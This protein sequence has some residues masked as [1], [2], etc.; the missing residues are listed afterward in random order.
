MILHRDLDIGEL[1]LCP[2]LPDRKKQIKYFLAS[3]LDE[4]EVSFLLAKGW[5]KFGIYFFQPSCPDCRECIPLRVLTS[6]FK[7]S[8]SQRRNLKKNTDIEVAFAPLEFSERAFE[9]YKTH[10]HQRFSQECNLEEF[11]MNFY[12]PSTPCLQSE[13]YLNGELIGLGFLDR[14]KDCLS[15]VYFIYD[16]KYSHLGLGTYSVLEE[17]K[18]TRSLGL[19]YYCLGYYVQACQKMAYKNNFKPSEHYDWLQDKWKVT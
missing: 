18:H 19:Q 2:Y 11:I 15:S 1:S 14:G 6:K 17:I 4:S 9:I 7:P 13:F 10:S 8:K 3:K 5:R 16:T 12:S